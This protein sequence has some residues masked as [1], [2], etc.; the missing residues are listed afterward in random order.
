[1][2]RTMR[3]DIF[4][5]L[6]ALAA[7]AN[8]LVL[9]QL[10]FRLPWTPTWLLISWLIGTTLVAFGYYGYDKRQAQAGGR[11]VPEAVLHGLAVAGGSLGSYA[12]MRVFRHKTIK[13]P[14]RVF[15]WTVAVM[16]LL[17]AAV[18]AWRLGMG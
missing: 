18:V 10:A 4:H 1:M 3:P 16:Q 14:F 17:L 12:G 9:I 6:V 15:F 8:I 5:A 7:V 11:R 13:G 2:P